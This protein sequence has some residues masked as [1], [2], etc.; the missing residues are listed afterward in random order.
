MKFIKLYVRALNL[1]GH[2][3]KKGWFLALANVALAM[4]LFAEPVLF[5][6]VIDTLSKA[7]VNETSA[8]WDKV[9][10]LL[11]AWTA[12]GLFTIV[13]STLISLFADRLSHKRRHMVVSDYF[14]HVLQLPLAQQNTTHSGRLMKIMLQG[15][16]ALWWLWLSFFRDHLAAIV[17]LMVLIP[18]SLYI[19]WRLAIVLIV[20]CAVFAMLTYMII[21]KT[22]T[23][24]QRVESHHSDM[25]AQVSDTLSNIPLVQSFARIQDEV[26]ALRNIS[27]RLLSVQLPVLSW[28]ALVT[29]LN[30]S[31]TTIS[32]LSIVILGTLLFTQGLI[33]IGA[34]V[35]F[36]AFAA[37]IITKL[38]QTVNFIHRLAMDAPRI[39]DFFQMMDTSPEIQDHPQALNLGR[40]K[41][42]IEFKNVC[43]S[44]D[45]K[46]AAINDLS[47]TVQA[48]QTIALVGSSGAGKSTALSLL[49]R[50]F[51]P[52]SGSITIDGIDIRNISLSSLRHNI[53]VVFQE[54]LLF[55]RSISENLLV[56]NPLADQQQLIRAAASAQALEFIAHQEYGFDTKIGERGRT[57]SGG[58]RQRISI[59]RVILKDPPILILDEA[60][61]ALDSTTE[62]KLTQ[63]LENVTD[64]R[65]TLVIAH[66]L[67]TIRRAD[68]ILVLEAGRIVESGTFD[69]LY[70]RE[71][72]FTHLVRE[73]FTELPGK[74]AP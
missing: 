26:S 74:A 54:P 13:C 42:I 38:E 60:T 30:R 59:A 56:G 40:A 58:E 2:D 43:F 67:A 25:A 15:T 19:N 29:V 8:I 20:L 69:D 5:G 61:S 62:K 28:W 57:L 41:G 53:G 47:F 39:E 64:N 11:A 1:L 72:R 70:Q 68:N 45:G 16:D 52:Q 44:Y 32:I 49:Y 9:W 23:L 21:R 73:Q 3:K 22:Q 18:L 6:K 27:N 46:H 12:F 14:E 34:I 36:I 50:A 65:S 48:G 55:N 17:S 24:Q 63:A 31:A 37:M 35:T 33:S 7:S 71:G 4:A 66:R 51:D 10:P